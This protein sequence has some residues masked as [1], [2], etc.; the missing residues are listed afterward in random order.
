MNTSIPVLL[1]TD[2]GS[3]IDDAVA[4]AYLLRQKR[5]ELLGIT[6]VSG[7]VQER[8]ALAEVVCRAAGRTDIPIHCGVSGP[9]LWGPGQPRVPQ[10]QAIVNRPHRLDRRTGD[11]IDFLRTTIRSRPGEITLLAIGPMTNIALLF[12]IDPELP[13]LLKGM[14][15]MAGSFFM[16]ADHSEW[17]CRVDPIAC[18]A[19]YAQVPDGH[20]SVGLDVTTKCRL[21]ADEVRQRFAGLPVLDVVLEMAE[22]WFHRIPHITFHDILAAALLFKPDLCTYVD[23]QVQVEVSPTH[24]HGGRTTLQAG[25]GKHRVAKSV[26]APAFFD[27]FFSVF[28]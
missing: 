28:E 14:V 3:D 26:D 13:K 18:A 11:G 9:I 19:T 17:N 15:S 24:E 20:I 16:N 12:A 4:I 10:Y 6:T 21:P 8:A 25:S 22:V 23:G 27:E 1:D 5:C 2:P 7:N